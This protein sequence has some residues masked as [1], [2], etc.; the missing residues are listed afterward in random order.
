[1]E[2]RI[3]LSQYGATLRG[4]KMT[5]IT[6]IIPRYNKWKIFVKNHNITKRLKYFASFALNLV[7]LQS[8]KQYVEIY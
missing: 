8:K 4:H 2:L 1:M 6:R 7:V 3:L 5:G